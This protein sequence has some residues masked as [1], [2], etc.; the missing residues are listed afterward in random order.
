MSKKRFI[1]LI[2][3]GFTILF[4]SSL[5]FAN[6]MN[7]ETNAA[8]FYIKA[9]SM[10]TK[11]PGVFHEKAT[12]IINNGWIGKNEEL[13]EILKKNQGAINEFKKATKLTNCDFTF[14]RSIRKTVAAETPRYINEHYL[15]KLVIVEGRLYE[16]ENRWDLALDNYLSVLRFAN[17]MGQQ[18][19]FIIITTAVG[20]GAQR[21]VYIP[22]AQYINREKLN[23]QDCQSLLN[24]LVSLGNNRT[25]LDS[26]SEEEKEIMKEV[27]RII[28]DEAKQK[29]Q[30]D[31][32][33]LQKLYRK[34]DKLC[35]KFFGYE[36][37]AFKKNRPEIY[38]EK[39][40]QLRNEVEKEIKPLNLTWESLKKV[41]GIPEGIDSPSLAAKILVSMAMPRYRTITRYYT[42]LSELNTLIAAVAIKLY[43]LKNGRIPDSLP[44]LIPTYLSK[45]PEDPFDDFKP[46]KYGKRDKEW[47]VYSFGPDRQDNHGSFKYNAVSL[48]KTGDIIFSSFRG[49]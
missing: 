45:L 25:G 17:H 22:L 39:I 19:D 1:E 42:S 49:E 28:G 18:K 21:M 3:A 15:A 33:Y 44:E 37:I 12:D 11:L 32:I 6:P 5:V 29:G 10:L 14:G 30:Y 7:D 27:I 35:D 38:E 20:I 23:S 48:D 2:I 8:T 13:K 36:I 9:G 41:A 40:I 34:F 26:A 43:E 46:L 24:S 47:V 4:T 31:E 16:K